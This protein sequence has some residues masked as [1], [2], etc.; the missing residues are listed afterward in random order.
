MAAKPHRRAA[1]PDLNSV[2]QVDRLMGV[3]SPIIR[4]FIIELLDLPTEERARRISRLVDV[5]GDVR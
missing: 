2:L 5:L 1:M 3:I 4:A